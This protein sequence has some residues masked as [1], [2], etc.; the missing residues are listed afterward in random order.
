M[1]IKKDEI[2]KYRLGD[3]I[4]KIT[5][6]L[7]VVCLVL[8]ILSVLPV[9]GEN[10]SGPDFF[11]KGN[12]RSGNVIY[13]GADQ[14]NTKI[15]DAID[16][17]NP[18]DTIRVFEGT[19]YENL[20]VNKALY[21]IGN[22]TGNTKIDGS[23]TSDVIYV[24][25]NWV[26]ITDFSITNSGDISNN[27]AGIELHNVEYC[28]IENNSIYQ[29]GLY[30]ILLRSS[31][32]NKIINNNASSNGNDGISLSYSD[33]NTVTSNIAGNNHAGISI[34]DSGGNSINYNIITSN[35]KCGI[36]VENSLNNIIENSTYSKNK[37]TGIQITKSNNTILKNNL[38]V[39]EG[40]LIEG[41]SA[42]QWNSH[43]ID[44]TNTVTGK[45][46]YYWKY[47][48]EEMIPQDA[49]Q[50]ILANCND[51]TIKN[52]NIY[53]VI[54]GISIAYSSSIMIINN[55]ITGTDRG[56]IILYESD[57]NQIFNNKLISCKTGIDFFGSDNNVIDGNNIQGDPVSGD[58]TGIFI[59]C[60]SSSNTINN[61]IVDSCFNGIRITSLLTTTI[62]NNTCSNNENG[63]AIEIKSIDTLVENNEIISNN[64][65]GISIE[66]AERTT[67]IKNL[68]SSN[69]NY[70]IYI[71]SAAD[72]RV[73]NNDII[74]NTNQAYDNSDTQ[75]NSSAPIGGN[76]WSDMTL[77][78]QDEDWFG[79]GPYTIQGPTGVKDLLPL[80]YPFKTGLTIN[81]SN[82]LVAYVNEEYSVHYSVYPPGISSDNLIWSLETDADWLTLSQEQVLSG[83]PEIGDL[84]TFN[85][86]ISV[87]DGSKSD[88]T[89]FTLTVKLPPKIKSTSIP[90]N[91]INIPVNI[92]EIEVNFLK[93]MNISSIDGAI[94]IT[95]GVN[96]T[97]QWENDGQDLK[98][99]F[100]ETLLYDTVYTI[101]IS[102]VITDTEG[103]P[104]KSSYVLMFSTE[105]QEIEDEPGK[106]DEYKTYLSFIVAFI[107]VI[108]LILIVF[109]LQNR[110]RAKEKSKDKTS[111]LQDRRDVKGYDVIEIDSEPDEIDLRQSD[112]FIKKLMDDALE[113]KKPSEFKIPEVTM[114]TNAEEKYRKGEISKVTYDSIVETLSG[115]RP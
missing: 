102:N 50:I 24:T 90:N 95:P 64:N 40:I 73:Y 54:S 14:T 108:L 98:I 58:T 104:L 39:D 69:D 83:T 35:I 37:G 48:T 80:V 106:N 79:D 100:N 115:E 74:N 19:Y 68:I 75:W 89:S 52:Q 29:N 53:D 1:K 21:I 38:L 56:G 87:S 46:I 84:S 27:D 30:G 65:N 110:R 36:L 28:S 109:V 71:D 88:S 57:Q 66:K 63:I 10:E 45:P 86:Q 85:I 43:S 105:I 101:T 111:K 91:A 13:V 96:Y 41:E 6:C 94:G 78:N 11:I 99:I 5:T 2:Q 32:N 34:Y 62:T 81:T 97:L 18:G 22:G 114:L 17:S 44:D 12:T 26:N 92:S 107:I 7:I 67:V 3:N 77:I 72:T 31:A 16:I 4:R 93:A 42:S 51:I 20:V 15:Q 23:G 33:Q 8:T 49:G 59:C 55:T 25:A 76:Y 60:Q 103:K 47:R 61:N 113:F 82:F 9:S 112:D 70:G